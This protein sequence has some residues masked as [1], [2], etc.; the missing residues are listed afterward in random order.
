MKFR[1]DRR[2]IVGP[3]HRIV[4]ER[5]GEELSVIAILAVLHEHLS[6]P[7]ANAAVNLAMNDRRIDDG[8]DIVDGDIAVDGDHSGFRIHFDLADMTSVGKM[9]VGRDVVA[10]GIEARKRRILRRRAHLPRQIEQANR[11]VGAG[12]AECSTGEL[13]VAFV[14]LKILRGGLAPFSMTMSQVFA[15]AEPAMIME[16]DPTVAKPAAGRS[17]L[18]PCRSSI[19]S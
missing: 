12:D 6:E 5:T 15:S 8:A 10:F 16:R 13:D 2:D 19:A 4:H 9:H 18:S 11:A 7:L 14:R 3:G 1:R 17:A